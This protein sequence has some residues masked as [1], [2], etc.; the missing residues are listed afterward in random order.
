MD[1]Y[2]PSEVDPGYVGPFHSSTEDLH[3]RNRNSSSSTREEEEKGERAS[4]PP[5]SKAALVLKACA[6][7]DLAMLIAHATSPNGFVNDSVRQK[8][9]GSTLRFRIGCLSD[10]L[11]EPSSAGPMLLGCSG[12][13]KLVMSDWRELPPHRDE[14][15]V[16]LDVNRSFIYYPSS[17]RIGPSAHLR[18]SNRHS[19]SDRETARSAKGGS[20]GPDHGGPPAPSDA[21]LFPGLP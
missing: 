2:Q 12:E 4:H 13:E 16:R 9:C 15:Q 7:G 3:E 10:T 6:R 11:T 5:G 1:E 17:K 18:L 20:L 19:R 21:L 8:A 14:D